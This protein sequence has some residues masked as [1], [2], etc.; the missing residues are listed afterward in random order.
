MIDPEKDSYVSDALLAR[1]SV[2]QQ[3]AWCP[4]SGKEGRTSGTGVAVV[5]HHVAVRNETWVF[6]RVVGALK[7]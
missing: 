7:Y 5:S 1:R 2:V 4:R 3:C 6:G